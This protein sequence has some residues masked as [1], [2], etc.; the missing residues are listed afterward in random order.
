[1]KVLMFGW[2][3]PPYS[4]GGL[5]TACKGLTK[6]L[7]RQ[8]TDVTFVVPGIENDYVSDGTK[9]VPAYTK[10][11]AS[12]S[13][14][15][16]VVGGYVTTQTYQQLIAYHR[17]KGNAS[18]SLYGR[19]LFLE[20]ERYARAAAELSLEIEHDVIHAH[21][22]LT[23]KAGLGAKALTGKPL[24]VH[25]HATEYDRCGDNPNMYVVAIER[26]GMMGADVVICVSNYT[27][28]LVTQKYGIPAEKVFVVHNGV[29]TEMLIPWEE[30]HPFAKANPIVLFM[31]RVTM[32]K[33]PDYFLKAAK[34]VLDLDPQIRFV[35][36]GTGDKEVELLHLAASMGIGDKVLFTGF[37]KG[38]EIQR[39]YRMASVYVMPSVSEPF[40]I[41]PLE[42]LLHNT[43]VI[44]SKQSGVSE[45]LTHCIKVDFWDIDAL[46][47]K[48]IGV[49]H[50]AHVGNIMAREGKKQA[51]EQKWEDAAVKVSEIYRRVVPQ[52]V[53]W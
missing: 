32:Q 47:N 43:P 49:I 50:H 19:D 1:M 51:L 4:T 9:V 2:E 53:M 37:L 39:M 18:A 17:S 40:G 45:V 25:M 11:T 38:N 26:E 13:G 36:A 42:S 21:D 14:S 31:G 34:R 46:A 24:V 15:K 23:Y 33:G 20:V 44:I 52:V 28:N 29:E 48:I 16:I 6:A 7:A 12:L 22:W 27:K 10:K 35:I 30:K 41:A 8:G 3:F 5:G